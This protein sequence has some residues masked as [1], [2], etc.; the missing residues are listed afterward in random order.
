MCEILEKFK[1]A[2]ARF[3]AV[4]FVLSYSVFVGLAFKFRELSSYL[5]ISFKKL[6]IAFP[7][8]TVL[9]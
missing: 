1:G 5:H 8:I 9:A 7:S 3:T 6:L 4:K 2:M